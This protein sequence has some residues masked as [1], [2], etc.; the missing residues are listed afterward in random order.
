MTAGGC[1]ARDAA[2][3]ESIA[4]RGL[5]SRDRSSSVA[6]VHSEANP[7]RMPRY[8]VDIRLPPPPA[9]DL[10]SSDLRD[11]VAIRE[12]GTGFEV[13]KT[14]FD[15]SIDIVGPRRANN[16]VHT[17]FIR[18]ASLDGFVENILRPGRH[19]REVGEEEYAQYREALRA[20][21]L[22]LQ[23]KRRRPQVFTQERDDGR[24]RLP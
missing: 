22:H 17:A 24:S 23:R 10:E 21:S 6:T 4:P 15:F 12:E 18:K 14:V 3:A 13:E 1:R 16:R 11:L 20:K 2:G 8:F 9:I 19:C 7:A 5:P